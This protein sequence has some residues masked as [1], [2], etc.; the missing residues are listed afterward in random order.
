MACP[1]Y[2]LDSG[3]CALLENT[4]E[5][6]EERGEA[7]LDEPVRREW[8]LSGNDA[9]RSCPIFRRFLAELLH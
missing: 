6:E 5:D 9:H 8:C 2:S 1:H 7:P 3:E 4:P